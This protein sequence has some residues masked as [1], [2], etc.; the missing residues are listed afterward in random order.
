MEEPKMKSSIL[1]R[2]IVVAPFAIEATLASQQEDLDCL[3]QGLALAAVLDMA[4]Q[5]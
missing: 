2:S 5:G 1:K 3:E 4:G